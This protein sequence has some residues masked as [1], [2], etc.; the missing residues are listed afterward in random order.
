MG[1]CQVLINNLKRSWNHKGLLIITFILPVVLCLI[2]GLIPFGKASWRIGILVPEG[3]EAAG[4]REAL[5]KNLAQLEGIKYEEARPKTLHTD[6]ITGKYHMVV[7]FRH[8]D[9]KKPFAIITYRN[10]AKKLAL[11][12]SILK[13][14]RSKEEGLSLTE[15]AMAFLQTLFIIFSTIHASA[16]IR[17]KQNGT[18]TRYRFAKKNQAG[19]HLGFFIYTFII[20]HF[21][22]LLSLVSLSIFEKGF[23]LTL[24]EALVIP[25]L[26]TLNAAVIALLICSSSNSEVSANVTSS[27]LAAIMSLLGGTFIS[28]EAMPPLLRLLS[29][30]SP[31]RW[32]VEL[33]RVI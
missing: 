26:M 4:E 6:L 9:E 20:T 17:D 23:S 13:G 14:V 21:Q 32:I 18:L 11:E 8:E 10:E 1:T 27:S 25:L 19:Y 7:D 15:R 12:E 29:A 31:N 22:L 30:L 28:I 24:M 33:L 2:L 5:Y 16:L 3:A